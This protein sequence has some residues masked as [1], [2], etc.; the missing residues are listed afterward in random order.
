MS[1]ELLLP[2]LCA[3]LCRAGSA[4]DG[5]SPAHTVRIAD[6]TVPP[7]ETVQLKFYLA[8]PAPFSSGRLT[9]DLDPGFFGD[10]ISAS[11][12]S[13][14]GDAY[15]YAIIVGRHVE[16]HFS[17]ATA[18]IGIVNGLPIATVTVSVLPDLAP[19][20]RASVTA[21]PGNM[22]WFSNQLQSR[23][24]ATAGTVTVGGRISI[25]RVEPSTGIVP[26]GGVIH[27]L[28]GGFDSATSASIDG[29]VVSSLLISGPDRIDVTL[30][31]PSEITGRRIRVVG[32]G[33]EADFFPALETDAVTTAPN[34]PVANAH[35]I[36]PLK[37]RRSATTGGLARVAGWVV[38]QNPNLVPAEVSLRP[39]LRAVHTD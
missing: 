22:P 10:V 36:L 25:R 28:G 8:T 16:M 32:A 23:I 12:F 39:A 1:R 34:E 4:A 30:G 11:A 15:G 35:P 2:I 17:S 31:A 37:S 24:G 9:V 5:T 21:D 29:V 38:V 3:V 7:G 27:I 14:A 6:E 18:S 13:G 26:A 33:N 19:G 20:S